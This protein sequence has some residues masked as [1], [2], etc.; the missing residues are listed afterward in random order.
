M[1]LP[2]E[3][4]YTTD[5]IDSLPDDTRA[6]LID[7]QI[8][9]QA[10]PS[11]SHQSIVFD[12]GL[13]IGNYIRSKNGNC[14]VRLAP[15]AVYLNNDKENHVEPDISVICDHS[16]INDDGCHGAPD[17][18]IEVVSPSS[19]KKDYYIKL[20]K[21]RT[22]SVKEYWIVDPLQKIITVHFFED[23]NSP[24]QYTFKDKIK[25]NIYDDLYIDFNELNI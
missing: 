17:F 11:D 18:I 7:G 9:Y 6:E 20:F 2:Q 24:V 12:L 4:R 5:F 16:K 22:A 8:Y 15:Y 21:Y 3:E 1:A 13:T 10:T 14:K 19:K 25:V 23:E